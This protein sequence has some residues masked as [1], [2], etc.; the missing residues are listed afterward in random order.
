MKA[1]KINEVQNFER[2]QEP[3]RAMDVGLYWKRDISDII[4]G[5]SKIGIK[6]KAV[7]NH[8][9]SG[10]VYDFEL[11]N[12]VDEEDE[13]NI[14][15]Y[16]LSYV[17]KKACEGEGGKDEGWEPGFS[18]ATEEG[19]V[20]VRPTTNVGQVIK[21]FAKQ[22]FGISLKAKIIAKQKELDK[23]KGIQEYLDSLTLPYLR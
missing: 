2:G 12:L 7:E 8:H 18:V 1:L 6:A 9:Y 16:Q 11:E 4:A 21:F 22:L 20:V 23:L 3:L 10:P 13:P 14:N 19:E 17:T 15:G 5:L